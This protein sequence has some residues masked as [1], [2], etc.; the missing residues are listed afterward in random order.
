MS[1]DEFT[2]TLELPPSINH[3]YVRRPGGKL[4]LTRTAQQY[5]ER[6]RYELSK[7]L[8]EA[9]KFST[10]DAI[11]SIDV[12]FYFEQLTNSG[13]YELKKTG[14]SKGERK[15]QTEFKKLHDV[16]VPGFKVHSYRTLAFSGLIHV[17]SS[18]IEDPEHGYDSIR[19]SVCST[20]LRVLGADI[21]NVNTYASGPFTD[22]GTLL[23]CII[24]PIQTVIL[25]GHKETT[26]QLRVPGSRI[27]Q[28]RSC[29]YKQAA[30]HV[31]IGLEYSM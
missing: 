30:R 28:S 27:E 9:S 6:V 3:L 13:W 16:C 25:G 14:P 1:A 26:A 31:I 4:A 10:R 22:L 11:Y 17:P 7:R 15:A 2:I 20:D 24:D 12:T 18:C 29:M 19:Y 8:L 23:D 5:R 21:V